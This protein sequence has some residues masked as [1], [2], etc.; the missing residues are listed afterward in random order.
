MENIVI[1][2]ILALIVVGIASYL[3]AQK[4]KGRGCIG[5]PY[6]KKCNGRC[7]DSSKKQS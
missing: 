2:S 4:K 1:I 5:C 7:A 6:S 3:I